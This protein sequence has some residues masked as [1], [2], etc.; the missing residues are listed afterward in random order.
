MFS[1]GWVA[2]ACFRFVVWRCGLQ[3][4]F[5]W[6]RWRLTGFSSTTSQQWTNARVWSVRTPSFTDSHTPFILEQ[7]GEAFCSQIMCTQDKFRTGVKEMTSDRG[8][9]GWTHLIHDWATRT[10]ISWFN[11]DTRK[12]PSNSV[13]VSVSVTEVASIT[14]LICEPRNPE[15]PEKCLQ[16]KSH[17]RFGFRRVIFRG[18]RFNTDLSWGESWFLYLVVFL[19]SQLKL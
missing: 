17:K 4:R 9:I 8:S 19:K 18:S 16:Y 1:G 6:T 7:W 10:S 14:R 15:L 13:H 2:E 5:V 11:Q 3:P 12:L